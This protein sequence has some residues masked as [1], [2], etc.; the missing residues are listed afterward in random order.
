MA[1]KLQMFE[2]RDGAARESVGMAAFAYCNAVKKQEG[3]TDSGFYWASPDEVAI[4]T[5]GST[6][7][8]LEP[9]PEPNLARALF[10]LSD[11]ARQT[12]MENWSDARDGAALVQ[13]I[14]QA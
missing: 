11:V 5:T 6:A 10:S 3:V 2:R 14:A 9:K 13:I 7:A 8:A 1:A 12:R 4:L